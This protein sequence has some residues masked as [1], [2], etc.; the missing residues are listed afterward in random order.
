MAETLRTRRVLPAE[1]M[2]VDPQLLTLKN[3]NTPEDYKKALAVAG[4][5]EHSDCG[6]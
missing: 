6:R 4:L 1:M 2:Q 3:L 5:S